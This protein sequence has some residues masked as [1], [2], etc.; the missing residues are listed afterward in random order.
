[1]EHIK[2]GQHGST[3]GGNP[4]ASETAIAAL[5]VILD[6]KLSENSAKLGEVFKN[7]LTQILGKSRVDEVRGQG[8]FVGAQ[9]KSDEFANQLSS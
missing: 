4:L 9:F 3:Y 1:M 8:L 5:D 2:P 6:E 7:G